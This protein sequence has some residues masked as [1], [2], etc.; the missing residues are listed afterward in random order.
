LPLLN[1]AT[2]KT[3][4]HLVLGNIMKLHLVENAISMQQQKEL[5]QSNTCH[6]MRS[7]VNIT[8]FYIG[9]TFIQYYL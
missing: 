2:K 7:H 9:K 3:T 1:V 4:S 6:L 5:G 8:D